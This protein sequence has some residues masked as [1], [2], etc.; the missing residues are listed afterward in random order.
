MEYSLRGINHFL[1]MPMLAFLLILNYLPYYALLEHAI[2]IFR[3]KDYQFWILAQIFGLIWQLVSVAALFYPPLIFGFN[4]GVLFINNLIWWP[5]LQ[6][7]FAFYIARRLVPG[8]DRQ[9]PLLSRTSVV[10][11]FVAYLLISFSFHIFA[12]GL[13]YPQIYQALILIVLVV[14]L[15]R[16]FV[17]SI[18][19]NPKIHSVFT[20]SRFLDLLSMFTISYLIISF[21]YFTKDQSIHSTTILNMQAL[22]INVPVSTLITLMLLIYS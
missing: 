15:S 4:V 20:P 18:K 10:I 14:L 16:V 8:I 5:T 9:D 19:S 2:G 22:R 3:L 13:L 1:K 17:K 6:A 21:L 12:P 7:L 11:F